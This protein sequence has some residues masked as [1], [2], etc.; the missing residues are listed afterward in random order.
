MLKRFFDIVSSSL[1]LLVLSPLFVIVAL[2]VKYDSA[3]PIFFRQKRVGRNGVIFRIHKF[4]T[5]KLESEVAGK[6]TIGSD[7]RITRSGN[8]L[9]KY[10]IDELP[11]LID[12]LIGKMSIV[13]PRPEVA[14]YMKL[15]SESSRNKILSLRPGITDWASI[16]MV[17]ENAILAEYP[18]PQAAYIRIIMP[19]KEKYYLEYVESNSF[20]GDILLIFRTIFKIIKRDKKG[21]I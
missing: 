20:F 11:Q 19:L 15:Y 12:V 21:D 14:E 10:K 6:L 17:D 18:D 13:G 8:F 3:G 16:E 2:W 9:R 5:M 1:G 4:R 7:S